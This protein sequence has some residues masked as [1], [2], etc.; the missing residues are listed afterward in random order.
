MARDR[1]AQSSLFDALIFFVLMMIA[2]SVIFVYSTM[3][4]QSQDISEREEMRIYAE[5]TR[6]VV[7]DATLNE[8]WYEDING[9]IIRKPP[10]DTTI[11]NLILEEMLLMNS[12][13]PRENFMLG[14]EKDIKLILN[15]LMRS[16][17]HYALCAIICKDGELET[18]ELLI[19]DMAP[20]YGSKDEA[21]SDVTDYKQLIPRDN[22]IATQWNYP[23]MDME[24]EV[25]V[26]FYVWQ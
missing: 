14:Y 21:T 16:G 22:L 23:M 3:L 17:Y 4:S 9:E 24:E 20:D 18:C 25:Q 19:S 26:T 5:N 12:G 8:T 7:M 10:G 11:R 1:K 6:D 13:V 15:K 2:S